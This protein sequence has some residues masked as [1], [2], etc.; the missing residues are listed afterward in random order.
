MRKIKL[1]SLAVVMFIS[2]VGAYGN[3]KAAVDVYYIVPNTA[4]TSTVYQVGSTPPSDGC[5]GN[6]EYVCTV[7]ASFGY[8]SGQFIPAPEATI[9]TLYN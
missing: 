4:P 2:A 1:A 3:Y 6:A 5:L 9:F 8:S 7:I